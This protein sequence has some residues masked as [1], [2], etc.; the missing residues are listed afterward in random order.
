MNVMHFVSCPYD[1][2]R[3]S[4][5]FHKFQILPLQPKTSGE[6]QSR[7]H[8]SSAFLHDD[9][10]EKCFKTHQDWQRLPDATA[11]SRVQPES[12]ATLQLGRTSA[13][14][15]KE[16]ILFF[17]IKWAT[18]FC[19]LQQPLQNKPTDDVFRIALKSHHTANS[20]VTFHDPSLLHTQCT[21]QWR[22]KILS[23]W[24]LVVSWFPVI[25][26]GC[27]CEARS[28]CASTSSEDLPIPHIFLAKECSYFLKK[29]KKK[30]KLEGI[31]RTH[32]IKWA[33]SSL[34]PNRNHVKRRAFITSNKL[35]SNTS[36]CDEA[37]WGEERGVER[38]EEGEQ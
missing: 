30:T 12:G 35:V 27:T 1:R 9:T 22:S 19:S 10:K 15:Q 23:H 16:T 4:S 36:T 34:R 3:R 21:V 31:L 25:D 20:R 7:H 14:K 33:F 26:V 13:R 11:G 18:L 28:L 2:K 32:T 8:S 5:I 6:A 29:E 37:R 38:N 17:L 24:N